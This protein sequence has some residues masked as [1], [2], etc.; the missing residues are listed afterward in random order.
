MLRKAP[1]PAASVGVMKP[2]KMAPRTP[3][4]TTAKGATS[5]RAFLRWAQE[6]FTGGGVR[7]GLILTITVMVIRNSPVSISPGMSPAA[8]RSTMDSPCQAP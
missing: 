1:R 3:T 6:Y 8:R 4:M 2:P 5:S 7:S